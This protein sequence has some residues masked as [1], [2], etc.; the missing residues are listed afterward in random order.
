MIRLLLAIDDEPVG[1]AL[2]RALAEVEGCEVVDLAQAAPS[3]T[4]REREVL[5]LLGRGLP[6]KLIARDLGISEKTVKAH[7]TRI[8]EAL[9]VSDRTQAALWYERHRS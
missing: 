2:R 7:V 9:G 3:L 4:P 8:F 1:H 6:N 5:A